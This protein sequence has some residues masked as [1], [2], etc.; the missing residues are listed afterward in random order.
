MIFNGNTWNSHE[1]YNYAPLCI[2]FIHGR[3]ISFIFKI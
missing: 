2:D 3:F 1:I